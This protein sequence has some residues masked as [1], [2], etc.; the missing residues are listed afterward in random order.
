MK[1]FGIFQAMVTPAKAHDKTPLL[2]STNKSNRSLRSLKT[3]ASL[4]KAMTNAFRRNKN[5][6]NVKKGLDT[7]LK[8]L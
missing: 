1:F 4:K 3:P 5:K 7:P 6:Y 2:D 8:R